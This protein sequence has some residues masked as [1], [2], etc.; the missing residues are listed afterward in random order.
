MIPEIVSKNDDLY[1]DYT[2]TFSQNLN[3]VLGK[4]I[5]GFP[6]SDQ[7]NA[8]YK[9]TLT[10]TDSSSLSGYTA[11]T[12][13]AGYTASS[14]Y[15]SSP[16]IYSTT[17]MD[18]TSGTS[19]STYGIGGSG[20]TTSDSS[21]SSS[22]TS[23]MSSST[24]SSTTVNTSSGS[25]I[26][27][28]TPVDGTLS[29]D[30]VNAAASSAATSV[31]TLNNNCGTNNTCA[32][33]GFRNK[34]VPEGFTNKSKSLFPLQ[35][36]KKKVV[37][38]YTGTSSSANLNA[39]VQASNG[40]KWISSD[41]Y[42]NVGYDEI[43][44]ASVYN[45]IIKFNETQNFTLY[46]SN[47]GY[48]YVNDNMY[49]INK[50]IG[51]NNGTTVYGVENINI[52]FINNTTTYIYA[53]LPANSA[54]LINNNKNLITT[55][56]WKS[57]SYDLNVSFKDLNPVHYGINVIKSKILSSSQVVFDVGNV[58]LKIEN[59]VPKLTSAK[60]ISNNAQY[61]SYR[62]ELLISD[63]NVK[64]V[65]YIISEPFYIDQE[66]LF[67]NFQIFASNMFKIYTYQDK[68]PV[69][70]NEN[71]IFNRVSV[72]QYITRYDQSLEY[73]VNL[74][75][76]YLVIV[77]PQDTLLYIPN[78]Q[79]KLSNGQVIDKTIRFVTNLDWRYKLL[80][81][82]YY[83]FNYMDYYKDME[84]DW[85][86]KIES[87][88]GK[89]EKFSGRREHFSGRREHFEDTIFS[90]LS[91]DVLEEEYILTR[92]KQRLEYLN[93]IK[94]LTSSIDP[95][96]IKTNSI[97]TTMVG[98]VDLVNQINKYKTDNLISSTYGI[99]DNLYKANV[100]TISG[101]L[102]GNIPSDKTEINNLKNQNENTY[103]APVYTMYQ[104]I[105]TI[106]N[107]DIIGIKNGYDTILN[108]L[109]QKLVTQYNIL[110]TAVK[111]NNSTTITKEYNSFNV[112][113]EQIT[114]TLKTINDKIIE[115][116]S[117]VSPLETY[118]TNFLKLYNDY[119][120]FSST[121]LKQYIDGLTNFQSSVS[122]MNTQVND[123]KNKMSDGVFNVDSDDCPF[124]K[125]KSDVTSII[126]N[127]NN[128]GTGTDSIKQ[129]LSNLKTLNDSIQKTLYDKLKSAAPTFPDVSKLTSSTRD[130]T[131]NT[132][133]TNIV[134]GL[135][136]SFIWNSSDAT[137][138][139]NIFKKNYQDYLIQIYTILTQLNITLIKNYTN[140]ND[141]TITDFSSVISGYV[142]SIKNIL[143]SEETAYKNKISSA[144]QYLQ[145]MITNQTNNNFS[146][147][148]D[149]YNNFMAIYC[150]LRGSTSSNNCQNVPGKKAIYDATSNQSYY[151]SKL[152]VSAFQNILN[153]LQDLNAKIYNCNVSDLGNDKYYK[154]IVTSLNDTSAYV[155]NSNSVTYDATNVA[156]F[157]NMNEHFGNR[158]EHLTNKTVYTTQDLEKLPLAKSV[159]TLNRIEILAHGDTGDEV[160]NVIIQ[161]SVNTTNYSYKLNRYNPNYYY[162]NLNGTLKKLTINFPTDN[163][164]KGDSNIRI[165]S[166]LFNGIDIRTLVPDPWNGTDAGR[167]NSLK[168][169]T[170]AW[171]GDYVFDF[172]N[173]N[174]ASLYPP[175]T[176]IWV[177][178]YSAQGTNPI[179]D[180][181]INF[182]V[183][184]QITST[185]NNCVAYVFAQGV[186][187]VIVKINGVSTTLTNNKSGALTLNTGIN[188]MQVIVDL[189]NTS[190]KYYSRYLVANIMSG[191]TT[192]VNTIDLS[193]YVW[194]YNFEGNRYL[195]VITMT[196]ND[197]T[198]TCDTFCLNDWNGQLSA[199]SPN[200]TGKGICVSGKLTSNNTGVNC[201]VLDVGALHC[202]CAPY[203]KETFSNIRENYAPSNAPYKSSLYGNSATSGSGITSFGNSLQCNTPIIG[204]YGK[205][206]STQL[207][208]IGVMC[209]NNVKKSSLGNSNGTDFSEEFPRSG[210]LRTAIV[211]KNKVGNDDVVSGLSTI[212]TN[213]QLRHYGNYSNPNTTSK[214]YRCNS[215]FSGIN[216]NLK[217]NNIINMGFTC[218]EP[219][220][221]RE[222]VMNDIIQ[223]NNNVST[224]QALF[225]VMSN[226]QQTKGR[227]PENYY[228]KNEDVNRNLYRK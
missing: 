65:R 50:V 62:E 116:N 38:K 125:Y 211:H 195:P 130:S 96:A 196:G 176:G 16:F 200:S 149:A 134:N 21:L 164:P 171:V 223:K 13:Y 112:I 102:T 175:L 210:K 74:G 52:P 89:R 82:P 69:L 23:D 30:E 204:L 67:L 17:G 208:S 72:D 143:N 80:N 87:F 216:G 110:V 100:A 59:S 88:S 105:Q 150:E 212:Y 41:K 136:V 160:M 144:Q 215:G 190:L 166:L 71:A 197:G 153:S 213:T 219:I 162:F 122:T 205:G 192:L 183:P 35:L 155:R 6:S 32:P 193:K 138:K 45:R 151:N 141:A 178:E 185:M 224:N 29:V 91:A 57:I 60:P 156:T 20:A 95:V 63:N 36:N 64:T 70:M 106:V 199:K 148:S 146:S 104:N 181:K 186:S 189:K 203:A 81:L 93:S 22:S 117:K 198:V 119:N 225:E 206:S 147:V 40:A 10:S 157:S 121:T 1:P 158:K 4:A 33:D 126:T 84:S 3:S 120:N 191:S 201:D 180:G 42:F 128:V 9:S 114:N 2:R 161:T 165:T 220:Y 227:V 107:M 228:S 34:N 140:I 75:Y 55:L 129:K 139:I 77:A 182:I 14:G 111:S 7:L 46:S 15:T 184:F 56:D 86:N 137:S 76:N 118:K 209:E 43:M 99:F 145:T 159:G 169:G 53:L 115:L 135:D 79:F 202:N 39:I 73:K 152:S 37:E 154:S 108:D 58:N 217:N 11:G 131:I 90:E 170:Y 103:G 194:R 18:Y 167:Y 44:V 85:L 207:N 188:F 28:S 214:L 177:D 127:I 221:E 19:Y 226:Y 113:K 133:V 98:F 27:S 66:N 5:S 68:I 83:Q 94:N 179:M 174:V 124:K 49:V 222:F 123:A 54:I 168:S 61:K 78:Y 12:S 8:F 92:E 51:Q 25:S 31:S 132:N 172:N 109:Y 26:S 142:N 24:S 101:Y 187:S 48:L 97:D 218:G 163:S 173:V 47:K